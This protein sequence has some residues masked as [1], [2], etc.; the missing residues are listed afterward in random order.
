MSGA[1]RIKD[2]GHDDQYLYEVKDTPKNFTLKGEELKQLH[3]RAARQGRVARYVV[4]FA[5][6]DITA[7]VY[8]TGGKVEINDD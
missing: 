1:G 2:D 5:D 3:K 6:L 4:H 8:I 7:D